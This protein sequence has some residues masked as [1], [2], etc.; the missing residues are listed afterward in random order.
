MLL[1]YLLLKKLRQKPFSFKLI[2]LVVMNIFFPNYKSIDKSLSSQLIWFCLPGGEKAK[3]TAFNVDFIF[4]VGLR[5]RVFKSRISEVSGVN[6]HCFA[7]SEDGR[8]FERGSNICGQLG[9][10]KENKEVSEFVEI[11]SLSW[12]RISHL[13]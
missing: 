4:V 13:H 12:H 6:S 11:S 10:G 8:V 5:G 9:T 2:P 7:V 1:A 3:Y